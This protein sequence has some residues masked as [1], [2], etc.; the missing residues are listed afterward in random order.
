[1]LLL[2]ILNLF[3]FFCMTIKLLT[4]APGSM[5]LLGLYPVC[6]LTEHFCQQIP[7]AVES[8]MLS[9]TLE[10]IDPFHAPL[11]QCTGQA[12]FFHAGP[13]PGP[14]RPDPGAESPK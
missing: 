14:N 7:R 1:M 8:C 9:G 13:S 6:D 3:F 5:Q 11:Q 10:T 2:S 4:T 12:G